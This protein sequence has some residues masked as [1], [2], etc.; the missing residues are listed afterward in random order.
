[1]R[2]ILQIISWISLAGSILPS[3]LYLANRITLDRSILWLNVATLVWFI[4][5]PMWMGRPKI[6]EKLVS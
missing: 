3:I 4:A 1:M 2:P 5:T 6:E